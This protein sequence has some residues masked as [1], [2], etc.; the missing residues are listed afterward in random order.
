M[1]KNIEKSSCPFC[2]GKISRVIP[3]QFQSRPFTRYAVFCQSRPDCG[4]GPFEITKEKAIFSW[5][6][7]VR[8]L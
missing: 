1:I 2:G 6:K 7:R 3:Q 4:V 5:N 8:N